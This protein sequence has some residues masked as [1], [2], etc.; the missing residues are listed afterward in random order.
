MQRRRMESYG[1]RGLAR[2]GRVVGSREGVSSSTAAGLE[3]RLRVQI[4]MA[5]A[6]AN[7]QAL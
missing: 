3:A 6:T 7:G 2:S 1:R 5:L 4:W